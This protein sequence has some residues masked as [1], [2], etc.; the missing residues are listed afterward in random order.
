MSIIR[1]Y[2]S[3]ENAQRPTHY[4]EAWWE[5]DTKEFVLH[6]GKVGSTG[7]TQVETVT[8]PKEVDALFAS[9][10]GQNESDGY[11][12]EADVAQEKIGVTVQQKGNYPTAVE[13][14]NAEKFLNEYTALLAWRGLGVLEDWQTEHGHFVFNINTIHRSKASAL[15]PEA[16]KKTDFRADRMRIER[17]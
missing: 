16:L 5:N 1:M 7:T 3:P 2:F 14:A 9:F 4:R 12:D 11:E 10:I 15:A 6:H 8:D 13:Q 17:N